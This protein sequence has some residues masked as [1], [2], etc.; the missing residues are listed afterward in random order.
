MPKMSK[1]VDI[2]IKFSVRLSPNEV[3]SLMRHYFKHSS[4]IMAPMCGDYS[5]GF[6]EPSQIYPCAYVRGYEVDSE[7]GYIGRIS[8]PKQDEAIYETVF[9]EPVLHPLV[10]KK[11]IGLIM[12]FR[13]F[14]ICQLYQDRIYNGI[15]LPDP[16]P[17]DVVGSYTYPIKEWN[18]PLSNIKEVGD[19]DRSKRMR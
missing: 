19:G 12:R 3:E 13:I 8:I 15:Y 5:N 4:F 17:N 16:L 10:V 1:E 18:P 7:V 11:G 9:K 2:P 6:T 14:D